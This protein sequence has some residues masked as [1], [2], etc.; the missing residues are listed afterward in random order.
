MPPGTEGQMLKPHITALTGIRC[1]RLCPFMA[2]LTSFT[3]I[4][5]QSY[6]YFTELNGLTA[7]NKRGLGAFHP[8][9]IF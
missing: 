3:V 9:Y 8:L 5:N 4:V 2:K 1:D 6:Q 7:L